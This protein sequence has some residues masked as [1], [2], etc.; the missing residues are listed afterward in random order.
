MHRSR[1]RPRRYATR[2][3]APERR[4]QLLEAALEVV[5]E[6]GY[7]GLTMEAVAQAAGVTKP[8]VYDAFANRDEVMTALLNR[9]EQRAVAELLLAIGDVP[10]EQDDAD[11]LTILIGA[12]TRAL[13][14]IEAR[15]RAYRLILLQIEGTPPEVRQRVDAGRRMVVAHVQAILERLLPRQDVDVELLAVAIVGLGEHAGALMVTDPE[16]YPAAR[17][18]A[19]LRQLLGLLLA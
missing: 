6:R 8:V 1:T 19:G 12:V 3:P 16:Q 7:T 2:L 17:F 13:L 10:E 9:E 15:P 11:P 5:G 4:E 14:A 18:E